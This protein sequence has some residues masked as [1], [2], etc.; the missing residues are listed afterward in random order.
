MEHRTCFGRSRI[1]PI[2]SIHSGLRKQ[3]PLFCQ[4]KV[5]CLDGKCP[6]H[7]DTVHAE[8]QSAEIVLAINGKAV[9]N[10]LSTF[11]PMG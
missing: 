1:V 8:T 4:K 7:F 3:R 2:V 9:K 11:S 5:E 10:N 6:T